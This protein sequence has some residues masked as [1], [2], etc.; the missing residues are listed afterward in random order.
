MSSQNFLNKPF[1]KGLFIPEYVNV[2]VI[3]IREILRQNTTYLWIL[4]SEL[5][6]MSVTL[7]VFWDNGWPLLETESLVS[8]PLSWSSW[9]SSWTGTLSTMVFCLPRPTVLK[10]KYKEPLHREL[11]LTVRSWATDLEIT[12]SIYLHASYIDLYTQKIFLYHLYIKTQSVLTCWVG[13]L[14][15]PLH[16]VKFPPVSSACLHSLW[17]LSGEQH[18]EQRL[19]VTIFIK[20]ENFISVVLN[21]LVV[22]QKVCPNNKK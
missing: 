12:F 20:H 1:H 18:W 9:I 17:R 13:S 11:V 3:I 6:V 10:Q 19:T 21:W 2:T 8:E 5:R 14:K 22:T 7:L 4:P 15:S 16:V